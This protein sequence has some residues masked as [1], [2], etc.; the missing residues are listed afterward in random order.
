M[1]FEKNNIKSCLWFIRNNIIILASLA[2]FVIPNLLAT[3]SCGQ[4]I[5]DWI[6]FPSQGKGIHAAHFDPCMEVL[7]PYRFWPENVVQPKFWPSGLG[8]PSSVVVLLVPLCFS[9]IS[10]PHWIIILPHPRNC[11]VSSESPSASHSTVHEPNRP[12]T[13]LTRSPNR[14]AILEAVLDLIRALFSFLFKKFQTSHRMF[15]Y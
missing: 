3:P 10:F 9:S 5:M 7:S 11:M 1:L 14:F 4:G 12:E 2:A 8:K 6:P 13:D 15:G